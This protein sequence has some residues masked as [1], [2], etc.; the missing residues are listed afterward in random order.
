M[1]TYEFSE[2]LNN[3]AWSFEAK[4]FFQFFA[5]LK[6]ERIF[7]RMA[8]HPHLA[9]E[10][11]YAQRRAVHKMIAAAKDE[12]MEEFKNRLDLYKTGNEEFDSFCDMVR[13]H[14]YYYSYSDDNCVWKAGEASRQKILDKVKEKGG[15]FESFWIYYQKTMAEQSAAFIAK[16]KKEKQNG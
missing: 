13:R 9:R 14:D 7:E 5:A 10:Y 6:Q 2:M 15:M 3:H 16:Q 11:A 1:E 4:S 12:Q 8:S